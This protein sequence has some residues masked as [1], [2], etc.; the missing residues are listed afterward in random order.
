MNHL[1]HVSSEI[2]SSA[3]FLALPDPLRSMAP[4]KKAPASR[5]KTPPILLEIFN[6]AL[7]H[8]YKLS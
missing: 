6:K 2:F 3:F 7:T 4:P 5:P 1:S 8:L